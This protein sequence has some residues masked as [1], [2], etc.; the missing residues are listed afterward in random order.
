MVLAEVLFDV[1]VTLFEVC[2][3]D[4]IVPSSW[5]ESLIVHVPKKEA[6]CACDTNTYRGISLTSIVSKVM[7]TI[8]NARLSDVAKSEELI[9]EEQGGFH[10]QRGYRDQVLAMVLLGQTKMGKKNC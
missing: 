5:R 8:L 9:K 2:W 10:Q 7:C 1:W 4:S 3:E 6:R